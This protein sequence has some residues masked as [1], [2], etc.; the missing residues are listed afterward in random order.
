MCVQII[1]FTLNWTNSILIWVASDGGSQCQT[2]KESCVLQIRFPPLRS[3]ENISTTYISFEACYFLKP[4]EPHCGKSIL[5]CCSFCTVLNLLEALTCPR[6]WIGLSFYPEAPTE[7]GRCV[8]E[9]RENRFWCQRLKR[10]LI[11]CK[12]EVVVTAQLWTSD[13]LLRCRGQWR[14]HRCKLTAIVCRRSAVPV[15]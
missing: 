3:D 13:D 9:R 7:G 8:C 2:N 15:L 10:W 5:G 12:S 14:Q 1:P 4:Q 6:R 11:C